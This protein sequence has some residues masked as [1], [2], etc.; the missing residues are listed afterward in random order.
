MSL[1]YPS[2]QWDALLQSLLAARETTGF[3]RLVISGDLCHR[4]GV[5]DKTVSQALPELV[6]KL[7]LVEEHAV[8]IVPGNHDVSWKSPA[9]RLERFKFIVAS[10]NES[11]KKSDGVS[12]DVIA[13]PTDGMPRIVK[14]NDGTN[15]VRLI[16][17][18]SCTEECPEQAGLG[19]IGKV[20]MEELRKMLSNLPK[21][22]IPN[23]AVL[24]HHVLPVDDLDFESR[25]N[26]PSS[27]FTRL[28]NATRS[29]GLEIKNACRGKPTLGR[30]PPTVMVD[31]HTLLIHLSNNG[32]H[33]V[34][35]G[36]RH[37]AVSTSLKE[38][39]RMKTP[40]SGF[41]SALVLGAGSVGTT[42]DIPWQ[43]MAYDITDHLLSMMSYEC[44]NRVSGIYT[45]RSECEYYFLRASVY[46]TPAISNVVAPFWLPI[47]K[48]GGR[49]PTVFSSVSELSDTSLHSDL[50][51]YLA[52]SVDRTMRD[53]GCCPEPVFLEVPKSLRLSKEDEI[54]LFNRVLDAIPAVSAVTTPGLVNY[55]DRDLLILGSSI[56]NDV[57]WLTLNG[58]MTR[59]GIP[60]EYPMDI[61]KCEHCMRRE[62]LKTFQQAPRDEK[63]EIWLPSL[64]KYLQ[65]LRS[66]VTNPLNIYTCECGNKISSQLS[67]SANLTATESDSSATTSYTYVPVPSGGATF[68]LR[69][70]CVI[71][72]LKRPDGQPPGYTLLGC[73]TTAPGTYASLH[74]IIQA[75]VATLIKKNSKYPQQEY[76]AA[77]E[78]DTRDA[79]KI[80]SGD[81]IP[82]DIAYYPL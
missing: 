15:G 81:A 41:P 73:G 79:Q 78:V 4:A 57:A 23:C 39:W 12:F 53:L 50:E 16:A 72:C 30:K 56:Y 38:R 61:D 24:H 20:Q 62:L 33:A 6:K 70:L 18:D 80:R 36:H 69:D 63:P 29:Y 75:E 77:F 48:R 31:T 21:D 76:L 68:E 2:T 10:V 19:C 52:T 66:R 51:F 65:N 59:L 40:A 54:A 28:W 43:F 37:N 74:P 58:L 35:H 9:L 55:G 14:W 3:C 49:I 82:R 46:P 27:L 34:L 32:V 45:P 42:D 44:L 64:W 60:V 67:A 47:A 22:D 7:R 71:V 11:L 17:L 5:D 25:S 13:A 26:Q 8:L 1:T